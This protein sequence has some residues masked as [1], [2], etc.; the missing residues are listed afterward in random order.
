MIFLKKMQ[1]RS[2]LSTKA[3]YNFQVIN[4]FEQVSFKTE[5]YQIVDITDTIQ[6]LVHRNKFVKGLV[7]LSILHTSASLTI[8]ENASKDVLSDIKTFLSRLAPEASSYLHDVEGPDDMPAHLKTLLTSTNLTLSV[9][10]S[11]LTLGVWQGIYLCEWRKCGQTR[12]VIV[13]LLGE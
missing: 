10:S 5:G 12:S 11:K 7:N 3:S 6:K 9:A 4:K 1:I 13:H 8:Q 2:L